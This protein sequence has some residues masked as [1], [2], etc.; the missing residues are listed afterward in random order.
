MKLFQSQVNTIMNTVSSGV[1]ILYAQAH[2]M[3]SLL[4]TVQ[5]TDNMT[6]ILE[7]FKLLLTTDRLLGP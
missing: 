6:Q 5:A 3:S 7:I 4:K 1:F 2:L